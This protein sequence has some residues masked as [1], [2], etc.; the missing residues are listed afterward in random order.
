MVEILSIDQMKTQFAEEWILVEDP[1]TDEA[2]E[3]LS[4]KVLYHS[5]DRDEF[6]SKVLEFKPKRFAVLY[7]GE[8]PEDMGFLL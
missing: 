5:R 4:G 7:L 3:V 1:Q 6:D 2:L 8:P